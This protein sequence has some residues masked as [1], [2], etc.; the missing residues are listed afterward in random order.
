MGSDGGRVWITGTL[1]RPAAC[2]TISAA[3]PPDARRP[4]PLTITGLRRPWTQTRT[5]GSSPRRMTSTDS[6]SSH[7]HRWAGRPGRARPRSSKVTDMTPCRIQTSRPAP[8]SSGRAGPSRAGSRT[9]PEHPS[10][11]Q[12][13]HERPANS[14]SPLGMRDDDAARVV[15]AAPL[16]LHGAEDR[17]VRLGVQR[18]QRVHP[19]D[20]VP[21]PTL[22]PPSARL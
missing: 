11:A 3:D 17:S 8:T 16:R 20:H 7:D 21:P 13:R 4:G 2:W 5:S 1:A 15:H 18:I 10:K 12:D 9:T 19:F 14:T 22:R 6:T